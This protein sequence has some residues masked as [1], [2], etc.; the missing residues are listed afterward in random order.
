MVSYDS[1][2]YLL[3]KVVRVL[4]ILGALDPHKNKLNV[5]RLKEESGITLGGTSIE[6]FAINKSSSDPQSTIPLGK[7]K[8]ICVC[9]CACTYI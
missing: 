4:G 2:L 3:F 8:Q 9:I 7:K 5:S 1:F 6:P